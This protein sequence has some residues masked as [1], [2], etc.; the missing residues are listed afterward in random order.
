MEECVHMLNIIR[1]IKPQM[2][3]RSKMA[4][5]GFGP[6]QVYFFVILCYYRLHKNRI[7]LLIYKPQP[8]SYFKF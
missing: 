6:F 5:S 3:P 8:L 4:M 1:L 7:Y 2:V